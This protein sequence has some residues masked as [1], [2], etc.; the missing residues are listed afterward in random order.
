MAHFA[1]LDENNI[2][3][4]VQVINNDD[5]MN[6]EFPASEPVGILFLNN[7]YGRNDKWKQTSYNHNFRK[8]YAAIGYFYDETRD[9]FIPPKP[10]NSWIFNE[11]SLVYEPPIPYPTDGKH[12][13]W[14]EQ[15][16]SW[17]EVTYE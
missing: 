13:I 8:R 4:E 5:V 14:D 10:F 11:S 15:N 1:K 2:V 17:L 6:L 7:L 16:L 9:A 12:Y 3:V